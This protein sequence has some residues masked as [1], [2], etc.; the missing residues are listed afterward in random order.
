MGSTSEASARLLSAT[1]QVAFPF[2]YALEA[3]DKP[4]L[5]MN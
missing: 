3:N 2:S 5:S 1:P 4:T